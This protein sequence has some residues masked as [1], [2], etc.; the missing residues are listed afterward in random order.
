[1]ERHTFIRIRST[2]VPGPH[3]YLT[4]GSLV[5]QLTATGIPD[6][7]QGPPYFSPKQFDSTVGQGWQ[8]PICFCRWKATFE[9]W[10]RT[11]I[12]LAA[13]ACHHWAQRL[14]ASIPTP[15]CRA[16]RENYLI[17]YI[18]TLSHCAIGGHGFQPDIKLSTLTQTIIHLMSLRRR[19][20]A[21]LII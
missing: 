6:L 11:T 4:C 8:L 15:N 10:L 3:W 5:L 2:F 14:D 21:L 17:I 7:T 16:V 18:Q 13:A 1:M 9:L 19:S 20:C 12:P